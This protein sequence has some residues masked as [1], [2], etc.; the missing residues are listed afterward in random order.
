[1]LLGRLGP[2][3]ST[4]AD[5]L[6]GVGGRAPSVGVTPFGLWLLPCKGGFAITSGPSVPWLAAV[7]AFL[8]LSSA[9]MTVLGDRPSP[10]LGDLSPSSPDLLLLP[11]DLDDYPKEENSF[12]RACTDCR[13]GAI[14]D[15]KSSS[16][17]AVRACIVG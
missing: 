10:V 13:K 3:C 6:A 1:M 4:G 15:S 14:G 2:R 16:S 5:V 12:P 11:A 9:T 8:R 17:S 7:E